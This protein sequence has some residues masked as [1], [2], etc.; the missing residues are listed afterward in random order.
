M[1]PVSFATAAEFRRWLARHHASAREIVLRLVKVHAG[2]SGL[3]YR[4]ALD[5]ALCYGWIDGVVHRLDGV[6][7]S[8]RFTPR[9]ARSH[10]SAVNLRRFAALDAL[11]RVA[12]PGRAAFERRD[13]R[14]QGR[15]SFER[16]S[17][18]LSPALTRRFKAAPDAWAHFSAQ[19]PGYRRTCISWVMSAA[20]DETRER[21]LARLIEDSASGRRLNML[22]PNRGSS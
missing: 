5:E 4:D 18:R 22:A 10:W 9:A 6:S 19:P 12:P 15:Y 14:Q 8:L 11:G 20:K 21:R 17:A 7:F 16:K 13:V 1:E 3:T 2:A